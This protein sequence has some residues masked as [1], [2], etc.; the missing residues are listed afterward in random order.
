[1]RLIDL[2]FKGSG[3]DP[4]AQS[5]N[6]VHLAIHQASPAIATPDFPY[7]STQTP[8]CGDRRIAVHKGIAFAYTGILSLGDDGN[9]TS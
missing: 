4:L 2:P 9:G 6:A 8:A 3:H 7:P 5:F 1:M